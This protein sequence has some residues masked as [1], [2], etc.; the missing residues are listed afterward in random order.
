MSQNPY[1]KGN[2]APLLR[3]IE[4]RNALFLA[5]QGLIGWALTRFPVQVRTLGEETAR[6][7]LE[8]A[9]LRVCGQWD[10]QRGALSTLMRRAAMNALNHE[11]DRTSRRKC[12]CVL[13]FH[14]VQPHSTAAFD[15]FS[16]LGRFDP[17]TPE[18]D[19]DRQYLLNLIRQLPWAEKD[20][21]RMRYIRELSLTE[22][23]DKLG[24]CRERVRQIAE[25]AL[26]R[27][28]EAAGLLPVGTSHRVRLA[29]EAKARAKKIRALRRQR[30]RNSA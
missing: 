15:N 27:L 13:G 23:G 28:R 2:P 7:L 18:A 22:I 21:V 30:R 24:I 19:E 25:R 26:E 10:P 3:T 4:E 16:E 5:N 12:V 14:D 11:A 9:L 1:H 17:P 29:K 20:V 6:D 8:L